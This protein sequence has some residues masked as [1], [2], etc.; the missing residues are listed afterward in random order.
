MVKIAQIRTHRV[1]VPL[2]YPFKAA[3]GVRDTADFVLLE[4][5]DSE[6]RV[7]LGEASTIPIYDEGSQGGVAYVID[8]YLKPILIGR[9]PLEINKLMELIGNTVKGERYS[10]CA[11]NFALYDLAGKISGLPVCRLLGGVPGPVRVC[12]VLSAKNPHQIQEEAEI[13]LQEGFKTFKLKVGTTLEQDLANLHALREAVGKEK[14]R[15]DGN[16]AWSPKE[17]LQAIEKFAPYAPEH[18]EQP[19]PAEDLGGLK[20][21]RSRSVLPVVADESVLTSREVFQAVALGA[22]DRVNIK[23]SRCGGGTEAIKMMGVA[24]AG[25]VDY[26]WGSMLELGVGTVASAHFASAYPNPGMETELIGPLLLKYDVLKKPLRYDKGML[27]LSE[28]PGL[29]IELD[30]AALK[31]F[32]VKS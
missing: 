23:I 17:A 26:F 27:Y 28:E 1:S 14:I 8:K 29:G 21:V 5:E 30:R 31:E 32:T 4:I 12:W 20:Y 25:G 19:V 7:G 13:K 6:G 10:R 16:G 2:L 11:V 9:N 15:L 24:R 22:C 3:Y 18:I